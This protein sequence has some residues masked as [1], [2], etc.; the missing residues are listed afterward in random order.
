MTNLRGNLAM[1]VVVVDA[2]GNEDAEATV[3]GTAKIT[4]AVDV[5]IDRSRASMPTTFTPVMPSE[6]TTTAAM[7][8]GSRRCI[9]L[10]CGRLC[11][12]LPSA[13]WRVG[14]STNW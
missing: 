14:I 12:Q 8:T 3:V 11:H 4:F 2:A 6:A 1:V 9:A 10:N 13:P 5:S 7:N